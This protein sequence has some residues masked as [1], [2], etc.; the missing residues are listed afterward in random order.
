[1]FRRPLNTARAWL[2]L[3]ATLMSL[4]AFSSDAAEAS[5]TWAFGPLLS[6]FPLTLDE[7]ERTEVLGPLF[8]EQQTES[9]HTF[10][11]P[12]LFSHFLDTGTDAEEWDFAYPVMTYD[13]FGKESRWHLFQLVSFAGGQN[14]ADLAARR[15]T[16]FPFYF[17]QRSPQPD[18]NYTAV[19]PFYGHL[20]NRLFKD[21]IFFT[22]FPIYVQTRKRDVVTDNYVFPF[23]H[24]RHGDGLEGWQ[25]WPFYGREHKDVTIKTNGFG[26]LEVIP[27]RHHIFAAW[28]VYLHVLT[29]LGTENPEEQY[30]VLPFYSTQR[31]PNRDSTTVLWPLITWTDDREK[32]F[33]EWDFP[34]P[35]MVI[36]RGE[37]KT[38]TRIFPFFSRAHTETLEKNFYL[39]PLY[40]Y[41]RV[42]SDTLD[43]ERTRIL[44]FL[45]SQVQ[46]RNLATGTVRKRTDLWP[47]FTHRTDFNGNTRLQWLAPVEPLFPQNHSMDR[48]WSPLWSVWRAEQ[49]PK[50]GHASQSLFWNLYRN[51]T[52]PTTRKYSLLFGLFQY[53][54]DAGTSRSRLFF[55]PLTKTKKDSEHVPEHR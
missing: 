35:L 47:L 27:G 16:I 25:L 7:G 39:W 52:A 15:L 9:E 53:Q 3:G 36:A 21:E 20:K 49:N 48:N 22:A 6:R 26:D 31:S 37:G 50:T 40:K 29:G 24:Q 46:L 45:Y 19:F 30:A 23:Y 28:P 17:Q 14:Q 38:I 13:R 11:F 51:E 54:S 18:L 8:Y 12:P 4:L 10:A 32:K 42:H 1:M 34:W 43:R 5:E 44:F 2:I 41:H 55:I 33:R